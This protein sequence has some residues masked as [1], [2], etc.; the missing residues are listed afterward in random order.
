[1]LNKTKKEL[2]AEIE[3]L[4]KVVCQ[5]ETI[6]ILDISIMKYPKL[7]DDVEECHRRREKKHL[8]SFNDEERGDAD[9]N[10]D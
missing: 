6:R 10:T 2:I 1:M 9:E 5:L 4:D 3:R 8:A 7:Y